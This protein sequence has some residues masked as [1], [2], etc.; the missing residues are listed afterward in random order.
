[1]ATDNRCSYANIVIR[2]EL[3]DQ[4]I[5]TVEK[6]ATVTSTQ[7]AS[8]DTQVNVQRDA[9]V[10][11]LIARIGIAA[12]WIWVLL[13]AVIVVNVVLLSLA[14]AVSVGRGIALLG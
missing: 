8:G 13:L 11:P 14:L 10:D 5:D 12:S 3:Y 7:D 4:G 1:M 9:T 2:K 6:L